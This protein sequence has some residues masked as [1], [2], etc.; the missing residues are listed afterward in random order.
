MYDYILFDLDGTITDPGIG[1]TNSVMYAL[2]RYNIEVKDRESL[3]RFIGPPLMDSFSAYYGFDEAQSKEAVKYYREYY[4]DKGIFECTVYEGI[5]ELLKELKGKGKKIILATS[6]PDVFAQKILEHFN[7]SEYFD[8]V[9]GATMD[10][11]RTKK[12]E[13]LE[14]A[15][16]ECHID[17]VSKSL[18]IGDR[19]YDILGAKHFGLDSV[20]VLFG[21]GSKDELM[22]AGATYL[23]PTAAD[24]L[25]IIH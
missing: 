6:K 11:K 1:I 4:S 3:Y 16:K 18:M 19:E 5:P 21:Y 12:T 25:S 13:V 2:N 23:A 8:F 10:E 17:D 22:N 14:Y 24:I 15:L 9:A 20:G 7:L